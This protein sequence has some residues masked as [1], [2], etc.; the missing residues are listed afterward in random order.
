MNKFLLIITLLV[1]IGG[2]IARRHSSIG[3]GCQKDGECLSGRCDDQ[4][5]KSA[6]PIDNKIVIRNRSTQ[7][8]CENT[9]RFT[10]GTKEEN[11]KLLIA[12]K[13]LDNEA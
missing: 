8:L 10:V 7:P 9:L 2:C 5:C 13:V 3:D 11:K 1:C 12:L 6:D 4:V